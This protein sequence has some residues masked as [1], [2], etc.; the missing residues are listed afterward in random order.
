MTFVLIEVLLRFLYC[1]VKYR[2][3]IAST[4]VRT[5][6]PRYLDSPDGE[7]RCKITHTRRLGIWEPYGPSSF[8]RPNHGSSQSAK[9]R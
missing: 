2:S 8:T 6:G 1:M 7:P 4:P 5:P 3:S 9:T